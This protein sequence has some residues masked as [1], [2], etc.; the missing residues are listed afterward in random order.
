[1]LTLDSGAFAAALPAALMS[2]A[3]NIDLDRTFIMQMVVF[4]ALVVLLKPLLF[5]PVLRVF[6]EREK[7]TE[8]AK[9]EARKMQEK[10]GELLRRY[11]KKLEDVQRAAAAERDRLRGETARL[12]AQILEEARAATAAIGA[13]GRKRIEGEVNKIR[14]DLGRSSVEL[15]RDAASR[16]LGRE[17]S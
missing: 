4:A 5:D 2:G 9:A 6:E 1:M 11:E 10:A 7:R 12:E 3:V 17:V 14:F 8:G 13:E 16:V 15:A